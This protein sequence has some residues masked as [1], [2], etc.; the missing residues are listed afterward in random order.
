MKASEIQQ[1]HLLKLKTDN[2]YGF[3]GDEL[4]VRVHSLRYQSAYKTPWIIDPDGRAFRPSDFAGFAVHV[5]RASKVA[6]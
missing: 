3:E 1:G 4:Y 2:P 6:S 5:D